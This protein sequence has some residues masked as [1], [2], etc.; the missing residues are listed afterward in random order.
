MRNT[1]RNT[2]GPP[3]A[4]HWWVTLR[5]GVLQTT[6]DYDRQWQTTR[7]TPATVTSLAPYT[8]CR[9]ASNKDDTLCN[10][11]SGDFALHHVVTKDKPRDTVAVTGIYIYIDVARCGCVLVTCGTFPWRGGRREVTLA[12]CGWETKKRRSSC[13]NHSTARRPT[14]SS[15]ITTRWPTSASTTCR[16]T[17]AHWPAPSDNNIPLRSDF[18]RCYNKVHPPTFMISFIHHKCSNIQIH[19]LKMT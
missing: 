16:P 7:Q 2:T 14:G 11:R 17:G 3:R 19:K 15:W 6:D 9:R 18:Y 4:A 1:G 5:R 10:S 8:M 12:A 13:Q